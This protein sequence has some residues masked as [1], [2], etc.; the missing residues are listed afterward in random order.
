MLKEAGLFPF[1]QR[2][3]LYIAVAENNFFLWSL[4]YD[5]FP[6]D[7]DHMSCYLIFIC[8]T[9]YDIN[10]IV[11]IKMVWFPCFR[12]PL[13]RRRKKEKKTL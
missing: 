4:V 5:L 3:L 10:I 13:N 9:S 8:F 6:L 2:N 1:E 12:Q 7:H 11:L